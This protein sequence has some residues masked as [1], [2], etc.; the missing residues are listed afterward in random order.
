MYIEKKYWDVLDKANLVGKNLCRGKN[1][2]K[3]GG[4]FYGLFLALKIIYVSTI[5][6]YGIIQQH[7]TFKG[8]KDSKR[9]LDRSQYFDMLKRKKITAILPR[10]W[11]KS[12]NNG[13]IIPTKK[14]QCNECKD[15]I[16]CTTCN[17][18]IDEKKRIRSQLKF[19]KKRCS[20]PIW[21]YATLFCYLKFLI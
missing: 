9:L 18:V 4:I 3:I 7:M 19:S 1:D 2:Y 10:L 8:Y 5:D 6:H 11:K 21:S 12:F 20:K 15:G 17:N 13:I 16:L 14:K